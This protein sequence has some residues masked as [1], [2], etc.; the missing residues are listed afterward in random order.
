MHS[1]ARAPAATRRRIR[2]KQAPGTKRSE[3]AVSQYVP[4][5][6]LPLPSCEPSRHTALL[7]CSTDWTSHPKA[8]GLCACIVECVGVQGERGQL[9]HCWCALSACCPSDVI[10]CACQSP[11]THL[12]FIPCKAAVE[13][14]SHSCTGQAEGCFGKDNT[15]APH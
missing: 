13:L 14:G 1:G 9:T 8:V 6:P 11:H 4:G 3:A 15:A 10:A 7:P 12:V 5:H 2:N